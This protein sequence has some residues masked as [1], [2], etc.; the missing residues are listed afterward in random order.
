MLD[1]SKV[2]NILENT[3]TDYLT[4]GR[5]LGNKKI[6]FTMILVRGGGN[7]GRLC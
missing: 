1:G 7:G 4:E 5:G 6:E 2:L 3:W